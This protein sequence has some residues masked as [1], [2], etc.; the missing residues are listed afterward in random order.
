MV[1]ID[2]I[3]AETDSE[4]DNRFQSLTNRKTPAMMTS[5]IPQLPKRTKR[6][7]P[8]GLRAGKKPQTGSRTTNS[9]VQSLQ[10]TAMADPLAHPMALDPLTHPMLHPLFS[11][12]PTMLALA[13]MTPGQH[14]G[15]QRTQLE[16]ANSVPGSMRPSYAADLAG[17]HH[18]QP[19]AMTPGQQHG[20]QGT[21]LE[22]ANS[23]PGPMR[24]GYAAHLAGQQPA[25][26]PY[27]TRPRG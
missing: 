9:L 16:R 13:P 12:P 10:H 27:D 24:E 4:T 5:Y 3:L 26:P 17:Q 15:L 11:H 23:V 7:L 25:Y 20:L 21:M 18:P 2:R 6:M 22:R 14:Y 8:L 1:Q 19:P